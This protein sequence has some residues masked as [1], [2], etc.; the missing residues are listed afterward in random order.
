MIFA[1]YICLLLYVQLCGEFLKVVNM[2]PLSRDQLEHLQSKQTN[3]MAE[4]D[5]QSLLNLNSDFNLSF[6]DNELN[7]SLNF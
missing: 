7:Q 6:N 2:A 3:K 5:I 4:V 1:C